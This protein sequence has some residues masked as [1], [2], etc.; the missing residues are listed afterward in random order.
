MFGI[1]KKKSPLVKLSNQYKKLME[2]AHQLS[3]INRAESD[4]KVAEAED[5][6]KQIEQLKH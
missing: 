1:F 2:Q 5:I 4:K 3:S 6:A